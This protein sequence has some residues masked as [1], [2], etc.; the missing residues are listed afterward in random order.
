MSVLTYSIAIRTLGTSGDKF[1][2][3]LRSIVSQ[4]VQPEK[5]V[6]YIAEGYSRPEVTVGKE[7]YVWVKKG[8]MT[9][10][11]L[12]YDEISSDC[13]LMLD[14]DV[15]LAPDSARKLLQAM[16]DNDADC[17][18]ADVFKNQDMP[19]LTKM[20]AV[21]TSLVFPHLS[22][23]WAFKVR[24]DGSFSYNLRPEERYYQSQSC[25]GPVQ[26]WKKQ[27][28]R[29]LCLTDELWLDSLEF[30]F[31]EDRLMTYKLYVNGGKLGVLYGSGVDNLDA[32]S[33]SSA[34]KKS[35]GRI[36]VMAKASLM[37]W[38]RSIYRNGA[39]TVGSRLSAVLCFGFKVLWQSMGMIVLSIIRLSPKMAFS[40][41]RGIS[42]GIRSS[43]Y[44]SFSTLPPYVLK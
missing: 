28:F 34:F 32:G 22:R 29:D 2:K 11:A 4:T 39:D 42:D 36:H 25:A 44:E 1:I 35:P 21:V 43:K 18:G 9:Q 31:A 37:V 23:K 30:P 20:K 3:E 8:M 41:F 38:W 14:D 40:F 26:L 5:V 17:V 33:S 15:R 27:V 24:R 10:R 13:I 12:P 6:V 7:E 19:F 16:E